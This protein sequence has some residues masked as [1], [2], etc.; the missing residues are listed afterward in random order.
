MIRTFTVRDAR[1]GTSTD[2][3]GPEQPDPEPLR[4]FARLSD[5]RAIIAEYDK[6]VRGNMT[7]CTDT[8]RNVAECEDGVMGAWGEVL[9]V[10]NSLGLKFSDE[11]PR[12]EQGLHEEFKR[13]QRH[14]QLEVLDRAVVV[15]HADG[16]GSLGVVVVR[17]KGELHIFS[18]TADECTLI[19]WGT[20]S[21][22]P[23]E[24]NATH[25]AVLQAIAEAFPAG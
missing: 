21:L 12:A 13:Y 15:S 19:A 24:H 20:I 6:I 7:H 18:Y 11:D 2:E 10:A 14:L 9:D 3:C 5:V 22:F 4:R 25:Q 23:Q 17:Y 1:S 16:G 8:I